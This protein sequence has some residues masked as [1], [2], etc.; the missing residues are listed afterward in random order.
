M[1]L[2]LDKMTVTA[3]PL[4]R[5][6]MQITA[7]ASSAL[8]PEKE[9]YHYD[10]ENGTVAG[11]IELEKKDGIIA[12]HT[13]F[14]DFS[15]CLT[16]CGAVIACN[17]ARFYSTGAVGGKSKLNGGKYAARELPS[18][19]ILAD[20]CWGFRMIGG[21]AIDLS[22]TGKV[23]L[24]FDG[25]V[26]FVIY[27]GRIFEMLALDCKLF[28]SGMIPAITDYAPESNAAD[29]AKLPIAKPLIDAHPTH[30]DCFSDKTHGSLDNGGF[31]T[32]MRYKL[33]P[34][35]YS[36]VI[37]SRK[38]GMPLVRPLAF[39]YYDADSLDAENEY[40][41][42]RDLL[43]TAGGRTYLPLGENWMNYTT[44]RC[45]TG[46]QYIDEEIPEGMDGVIFVRGGASIPM[47][48]FDDRIEYSS[49][50][51]LRETPGGIDSFWFYES[52]G[53]A[54]NIADA[55]LNK[56]LITAYQDEKGY[57]VRMGE[58]LGRNDWMSL[59]RTWIAEMAQCVVVSGT[60]VNCRDANHIVRDDGVTVCKCG[61]P[62]LINIRFRKK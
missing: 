5:N 31:Y 60:Y 15:V 4:A 25:K 44:G 36:Q 21:S 10:R 11:Q 62:W 17:D 37:E 53:K 50:L 59:K 19:V 9:F 43:I 61:E 2:K 28:G 32:K 55:K 47:S 34:Y 49:E 58:R 6:V 46:G 52:D 56:T 38:T 35:I 13:Y 48:T 8:A 40:M 1:E 3:L 30:F 29:D 54:Q 18:P 22:E 7:D 33:I 26:N 16:D 23:K 24:T 27:A 41:F 51:I 39:M 12:V 57:L 20:T 45:Y 14:A 42:G